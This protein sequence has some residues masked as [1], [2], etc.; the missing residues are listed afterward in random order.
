MNKSNP[1]VG[2]VS[3]STQEEPASLAFDFAWVLR[4]LS[5]GDR[6]AERRRTAAL[7]FAQ[8]EL[9]GDDPDALETFIEGAG[10]EALESYC[11]PYLS[12]HENSEGVFGFWPD[13][14]TLEEDARSRSG[15][16]KVNAG[17]PWPPL[18]PPHGDDIQYVME[19]TDHGNVTLYNRRRVEIWSCV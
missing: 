10:R 4:K 9:A 19:V 15:V 11:T 1:S 17:D 8:Y 6:D 5:Q 13:I 14:T 16:V 18:W 2:A 7:A 3:D 12:F